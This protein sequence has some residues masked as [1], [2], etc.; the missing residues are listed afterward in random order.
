MQ[1]HHSVAVSAVRFAGADTCQPAPGVLDAMSGADVIVI[2]PSNPI[3][4]IGPLLAVPGVR[5]ELVARRDHVVAISPIVAGAA[6]KGPADRLM[7]ELGH[8]ASVAGVARIYRELVAPL[9]IDTADVALRPAV[10]AEGVR[11][12]V[13]DTIMADPVVAR[14]LALTTL[15][16]GP[17]GE[18]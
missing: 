13:T 15:T 8:V 14:A 9:V 11:C 12:V 3:V 10:A 7:T 5:D 4:S 17:G 6:L 1:R 2:A 16:A 18:R